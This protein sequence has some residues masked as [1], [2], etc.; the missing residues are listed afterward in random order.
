M[1]VARLDGVL[2]GHWTVWREVVENSNGDSS[3]WHVVYRERKSKSPL[4]SPLRKSCPS[5]VK[6]LQGSL[7]ME[8][9]KDVGHNAVSPDALLEEVLHT[10]VCRSS[11]VFWIFSSTYSF[12]QFVLERLLASWPRREASHLRDSEHCEPPFTAC[13]LVA[14]QQGTSVWLVECG[15]ASHVSPCSGG[16]TGESATSSLT[17]LKLI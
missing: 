12:G 5:C 2:E 3:L 1:M 8:V 13:W 17:I 6:Q 11:V 10:D 7:R 16:L 4:L 15:L 9:N 14:S